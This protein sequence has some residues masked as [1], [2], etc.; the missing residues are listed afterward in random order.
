MTSK[1]V[2]Y[3]ISLFLCCAGI[4]VGCSHWREA[5]LDDSLHAATQ[6]EV[7]EKLG[8]PHR[9]NHSLLTDETTWTYRYAL[10]ES[11]LKPMDTDSLGRGLTDIT[12]QAA[13][14]IGQPPDPNAPR[15][16]VVCVEYYLTF[17][18]SHVLQKWKRKLCSRSGP[19][20]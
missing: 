18:K 3:H 9:T 12:S 5:Y 8:P 7:K 4:L 15:E 20:S 6:E 13:A 1:T 2:M 10:D 17:D 16:K 19:D 14:M 11:D